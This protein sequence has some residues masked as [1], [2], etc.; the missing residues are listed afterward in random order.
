MKT[1]TEKQQR[2][3]DVLFDEAGGDVVRAKELAGYSPNN[4]TTEIIKAIKEEVV[5]ATQ[6][7]MARNAPRAAMS[8]VSGM[9]EPTEL[10]MKDKLTAAKDLL[11]RVGLVKTEKLQVEASNGLMILPPKDSDE[12]EA[13]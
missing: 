9:V 12:R 8:I 4:S 5:E 11:D 13:S 2:F 10:G 7:Y 6:L 3:L 1:L